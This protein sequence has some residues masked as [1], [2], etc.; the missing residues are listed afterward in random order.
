[1]TIFFPIRPRPV[2]VL[3]DAGPGR[4]E[5]DVN[6]VRLAGRPM[7][8]GSTAAEDLCCGLIECFLL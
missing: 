6:A 3:A 4:V 5:L 2:R 8:I 7:Q 1:M